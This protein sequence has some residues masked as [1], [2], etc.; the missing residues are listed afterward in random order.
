MRD[1]LSFVIVETPEGNLS[2]Q[3]LKSTEEAQTMFNNCF[4]SEDGKMSRMTLV[5][6]KYEDGCK[7][8]ASAKILGIPVKSQNGTVKLE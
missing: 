4:K 2:S 6:L 5:V 3:L 1:N 8:E 7:I